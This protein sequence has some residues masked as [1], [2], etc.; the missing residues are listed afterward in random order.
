MM[1][2]CVITD[3]WRG[4]LTLESRLP[5]ESLDD[6]CSPDAITNRLIFFKSYKL[7][8]IKMVYLCM[9]EIQ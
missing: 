4:L 8:L 7:K 2:Y 3:N 9:N 5:L 1:N 6:G